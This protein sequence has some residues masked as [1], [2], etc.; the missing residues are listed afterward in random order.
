M[1]LW[2]WLA[3]FNPLVML[4]SLAAKSEISVSQLSTAW[5]AVVE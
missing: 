5:P 3:Y 2:I 4:A 1:Q